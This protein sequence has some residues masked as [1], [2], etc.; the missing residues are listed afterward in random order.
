VLELAET[1][2]M[3]RASGYLQ[4]LGDFRQ[5]PLQLSARGV[6]VTLGDVAHIQL[7]PEMRRGIAELD[8]EGETVGG[9]V[10]LRSGKNARETLAAVHAKLEELKSSLPEG[11][12]IVT[13]Y[14]RSELIDRAVENL[15]FKL[16]E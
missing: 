6:P 9:V 4:T 12:E 1:E 10:I 7:G 3:V 13:T 15:S 11:V 14:D 5:I 16:L 2:Y 8:G